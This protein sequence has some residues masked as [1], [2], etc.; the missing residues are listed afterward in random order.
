MY[1]IIKLN[2]KDVKGSELNDEVS[3]CSCNDCVLPVML[4]CCQSE[5]QGDW[6]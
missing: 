3:E 2:K 5:G 4:V 1:L 6:M